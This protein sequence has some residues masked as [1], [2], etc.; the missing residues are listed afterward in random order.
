MAEVLGDQA[1]LV[2]QDGFGVSKLCLSCV[3]LDPDAPFQHTSIY[4]SSQCTTDIITAY[5]EDG[6]VSC[7]S[8]AV[9]SVTGLTNITLRQVPTGNSSVPT[10]CPIDGWVEVFPG[11]KSVD[12]AIDRCLV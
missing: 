9:W 8:I 3:C 11:V 2:Q 6:T 12:I 10:L 1:A 5:L 4:Q 7:F